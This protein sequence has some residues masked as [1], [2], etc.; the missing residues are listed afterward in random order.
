MPISVARHC[1]FACWELEEVAGEI[2]PSIRIDNVAVTREQVQELGIPRIPI[3]ENDLRKAQ[4]ELTHG[5]GAVEVD[6]LEAVHPGKL[7]EVLVERIEELR[8]AELEDRVAE[9]RAEAIAAVREAINEVEEAHRLE[10]EDIAE[11]A[12]AIEERYRAFYRIL[13]EEVAERYRRLE[14]RFDRHIEP[15]QHELETVAAAVR[16]DLE[17]LEVGLPELP[18]GEAD[19]DDERVWLFDSGRDF[20]E[21]TKLFRQVQGKE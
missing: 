10:L 20:V 8:D 18:E 11:R 21:Q 1:Q 19:E 5:K 13:G 15:L 12:R 6:A 9:T 14:R 2:A 4:F 3:K 17:D 16:Q 7:Q